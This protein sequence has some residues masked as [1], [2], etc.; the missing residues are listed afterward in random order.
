MAK[1][2]QKQIKA[3]N[4]VAYSRASDMTEAEKT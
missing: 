2:S 4:L 1:P 3:R